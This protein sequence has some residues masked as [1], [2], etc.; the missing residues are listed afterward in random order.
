MSPRTSI[1]IKVLREQFHQWKY[2]KLK[3]YLYITK[4]QYSLVIRVIL[5]TIGN[6]G[7]S[8]KL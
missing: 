1:V 4:A 3:V 5:F 6:F 7:E 8:K 2:F